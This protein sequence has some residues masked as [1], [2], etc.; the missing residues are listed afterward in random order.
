MSRGPLLVTGATG[1]VGRHV[2]EAASAEGR[3]ALALVRDPK[4]WASY[5]WTE[6]LGGLSI[7]T[8]DVTEP[9]AWCEAL[10]PLGGI[11]HLAALVRH[12]RH[13]PDDIF[14]TNVGGTLAMVRLAAANRCRLVVFSTSGTVGCFRSPDAFA[15][16]NAPYCDE[17]VSRWPY[18]VSKIRL[19]R[20]ARALADELGVELVFLRPP[21]L[22][23]PG[24][25]R[26]RST[27]NVL[28]ALRR[29]LPFIIRGGMHFAD[30]RDAARALLVALERP[31]VQPVYHL[32]GTECGLEH[33]FVM[34]EEISGVPRPR[35]VLPYRPA[36]W[37]ATA[38][39]RLGVALRGE[40][41]HLLPDPVV[42]EM[43]AHYWGARSLHA[44]ADLGYKPR[45]PRETLRDTVEW[46]LENHEAFQD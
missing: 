3:P 8:G 17:T 45:D 6:R 42:V 14:D 4:L 18:Y 25:H 9:E 43:A 11:A 37:L 46:L 36:W 40:P 7:V 29:K 39:H 32:E 19:E 10:P 34:L 41:P 27:S 1:F 38:V 26:Y 13:A 35:F 22:L 31:G 5:D 23:G 44:A 20:E 33:F 2:L 28:K 12:S 24:D 30:V 16:E 21:I 15:D